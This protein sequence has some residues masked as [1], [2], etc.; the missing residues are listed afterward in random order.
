[1]SVFRFF[2][3][4][5]SALFLAACD[6]DLAP[7]T[8]PTPTI[9]PIVAIMPTVNNPD[10]GNVNADQFTPGAPPVSAGNPAVTITPSPVSTAVSFPMQFTASDG[11]VIAATYYG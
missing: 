4:L 9:T 7:T 1:M 6:T 2:S 11:L 10:T 8:P 3:I 5:L